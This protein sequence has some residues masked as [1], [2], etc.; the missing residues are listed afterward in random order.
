MAPLFV[1]EYALILL[2]LTVVIVVAGAYVG[3]G[4]SLRDFGKKNKTGYSEV[5]FPEK[6][7]YMTEFGDTI[8]DGRI[9]A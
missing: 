2:G 8:W 7:K 4:R 1:L 3:S 9:I 6:R 5:F